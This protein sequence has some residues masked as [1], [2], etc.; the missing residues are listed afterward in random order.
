MIHILC[1]ITATEHGNLY[2]TAASIVKIGTATQ[3]A[4]N[5]P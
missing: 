1:V 5:I 3:K 4:E 2:M